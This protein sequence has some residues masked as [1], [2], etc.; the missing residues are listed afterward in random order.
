MANRGVPAV[1]AILH[2]GNVNLFALRVKRGSGER[3]HIFPANQTA[4]NAVWRR[5]GAQCRSVARAPDDS[6][7]KGRYYFA[8][9]AEYGTVEAKVEQCIVQRPG[10]HRTFSYSHR[11]HDMM[12]T[13]GSCYDIRF[14]TR[15]RD[16]LFDKSPFKG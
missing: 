8:M 16:S 11:S 5:D 3:H 4:Q 12:L 2:R 9:P 1:A 6:F 14:G 13:A 15:Y 10:S 7:N